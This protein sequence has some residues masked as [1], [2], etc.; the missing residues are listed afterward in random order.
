M[1]STPKRI[2]EESLSRYKSSNYY[3][4]ILGDV[5]GG[6]YVVKA[7]LGFGGHSTTWL[8]TDERQNF[9]V[10][11]VLTAESGGSR[12]AKVF[13][14]IRSQASDSQNVGKYC[15][16]RPEHMFV[17]ESKGNKHQCFIF[18]PLGPNLLEFVS[19]H[20]KPDNIQ[21]TISG[22]EDETLRKLFAAEQENPSTAKITADGSPIYESRKMMQDDLGFP[23]LCDLGSAVIGERSRTGT[24]QA[25]PYRAPEVLLGAA[26]DTKIDIWSLGVLIW[27]L[28]LG[29]RLFGQGNEVDTVGLMVQYLGTPPPSL[30]SRCSRRSEYFDAK[31][32]WRYEPSARVRLEDRVDVTTDLPLFFDMLYNMLKWD[33]GERLP[34]SQLL[35]HPW[36]QV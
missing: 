20:I 26:W 10:L 33:P 35:K 34:A 32:H 4:V 8:C 22:N 14:H 16:R 29:E 25:L 9:K 6:Q 17:T 24:V 36:L 28:T 30:L 3:P 15:V 2:E 12:E 11:K 23:I 31:G 13:A 19:N 27:E 21:M 7:K 5:I 1:T 18:A